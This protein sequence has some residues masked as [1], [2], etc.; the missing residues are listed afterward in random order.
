[1]S[2]ASSSHL[3]KPSFCQQIVFRLRHPAFKSLKSLFEHSAAYKQWRTYRKE[4]PELQL[5]AYVEWQ[6]QRNKAMADNLSTGLTKPSFLQVSRMYVRWLLY[7]N[8]KHI[9]K[10]SPSYTQWH[11][12]R[13]EP[14]ALQVAGYLRWRS[15]LL[16]ETSTAVVMQGTEAEARSISLPTCDNP[17][18]SVIIPVYNKVEYTLTCLQ[19]IQKNPP[20]TAF[21]VIVID[22]C[23]TD[24]TAPLL[25]LVKGLEVLRNTSNLGFVKNC[26]KAAQAARG[27]Y[28]LF[29]NNDTEVLPGWLDELLQT[30]SNYP[31]AGLVGSKLIY[32]N[33]RLQEAGGIVW[34]DASGSNYGRNADPDRPAF[35]YVR[36][37]DYCSGASIMIPT[38]LFHQLGGF[39]ERYAPAYYEDTDLAFA[40]RKAGRRV[41]FQPFSRIIHFEGISS[42]TDVKQGVKA[43]QLR[44]QEIFLAKWR[45]ELRASGTSTQG[46]LLARERQ[47]KKRA[48]VIDVT[49]PKPDQDSGSVDTV[50]YIKLLQKLG[51]KVT[52]FP[53]DLQHGGRYAESLQRLG[54][55]CLFSPYVDSVTAHL[56]TM[57]TYYDL[58]IVNRVDIASKYIKPLRRYCPHAKIIFN[59]VDL[60]FL[61]EERQAEIEGSA[62]LKKAA[63]KT[64]ALEQM[65]MEHSDA[66]IL[67]SS[68]E[69]EV[70]QN[71]WPH[72]RAVTIPYVREAPGCLTPFSA[73]SGIVFI[74]GF[75]HLP[76]VDAALYFAH[77]IWPIVHASI[78]Q[79][80]FHIVGSNMV[81]EIQALERIPGIVIDGHV[82][83]LGSVFNHC[84]VSVAPLRFGAGIKGKIGTSLGFGVPCVATAVAAEGM[85]LLNHRDVLIGTDPAEFAA[86]VIRVYSD[87]SLWQQLSKNGI[88]FMQTHHSF[89]R[90]LLLLRSLIESIANPNPA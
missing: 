34:Q 47:V 78:P 42:G 46:E 76:N 82:A 6:R 44:N 66:T 90:G 19:S 79:A 20:E 31:D 36:E 28:I 16:E 53:D 75:K 27:K 57:G 69:K 88:E 64:K 83:D 22:D 89:E 87:E 48:I 62:K 35:C 25:A 63:C 73:R 23:S 72:I 71:E 1:M 3:M 43:Y 38:H 18:V 67:I 70:I 60:H 26:N 84:R 37:A 29:L 52:F 51:Y 81:P 65:A 77:E 45:E 7:R 2:R 39:D 61:R 68:F 86:A 32:P 8:L 17:V 59:T 85:Q 13:K 50:N 5:A 74:G 58:A 10:N 12:L 4:P 40:V 56:E 55:E 54:V 21:E 15:N 9:F 11:M 30:F 80:E 41:L 33:G 14:S 24:M 49:A